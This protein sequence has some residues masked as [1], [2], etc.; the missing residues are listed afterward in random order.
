[1]SS[2]WIPANQEGEIFSATDCVK[3]HTLVW[4]LVFAVMVSTCTAGTLAVLAFGSPPSLFTIVVMV[5]VWVVCVPAF[6]LLTI[7]TCCARM[8]MESGWR[9]LDRRMLRNMREKDGF[10]EDEYTRPVRE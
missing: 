9:A 3:L 8:E 1:M 10:A 4:F 6:F 7:R 5:L 2:S